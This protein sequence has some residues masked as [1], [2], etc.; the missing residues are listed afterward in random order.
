[1]AED[2]L[3]AKRTPQRGWWDKARRFAIVRIVLGLVTIGVVL[4]ALQLAF[5]TIARA[6]AGAKHLFDVTYL[7]VWLAIVATLFAYNIFVRWVEKRRATEIGSRGAVPEI[8]AGIGLGALMFGLTIGVLA[9]AGV[10]HCNGFNTWSVLIGAIAAA[11][12][13]AV[14]EEIIFRGIIFRITEES[15]GT[16]LALA[17][18]AVIFGAVHLLNPHTSVQ[19]AIAIVLEAGIFLAA[20][21]MIT[22]RLWF[23]IGAHFGWNFTESGIFGAA[24]SGNASHG[25]IDSSVTGPSSLSGGVFGVEASVVAIILCL[26]VAVTLLVWVKGRGGFVAP[27]WKRRDKSSL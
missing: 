7:P 1:M 9:L 20:A 2:R 19:G 17:I 16:W 8:A 22:R 25:L 14:I 11:V 26:G 10:Y 12:I 13:S 18:S 4:A 21:Y 6:N 5:G 15:L 24:V 27:F 3:T 23:V